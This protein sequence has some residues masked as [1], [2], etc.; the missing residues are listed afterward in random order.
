MLSRDLGYL[1]ADR[2]QSVRPTIVAIGSMLD[3]LRRQ[4]SAVPATP[5]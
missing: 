1:T 3:A 4:V 5:A 2:F